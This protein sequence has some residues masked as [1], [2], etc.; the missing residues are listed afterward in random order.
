[1]VCCC[2]TCRRCVP[3]RLEEVIARRS[4]RPFDDAIHGQDDVLAGPLADTN[5]PR[6]SAT[7]SA[8]PSPSSPRPC[9]GDA[10]TAS[11][12]PQPVL[13]VNQPAQSDDFDRQGAGRRAR[14]LSSSL[15]PARTDPARTPENSLKVIAKIDFLRIFRR[16]AAKE[17]QLRNDRRSQ[18]QATRR[19]SRRPAPIGGSP[20]SEHRGPRFFPIHQIVLM[21]EKRSYED[22]A[23]RRDEIQQPADVEELRDC[24]LTAPIFCSTSDTGDVESSPR[25]GSASSG[26][27]ASA[28]VEA[29]RLYAAAHEGALPAKLTDVSVP[30]P[31]DP[32][33]GQ[34]FRYELI[35]GTA[36]LRGSPP[37]GEEKRPVQPALRDHDPQVTPL[38]A[39]S[40]CP[41][42]FL[43]DPE[44]S[45]AMIP[46]LL[47]AVSVVSAVCRRAGNRDSASVRPMAAPKPARSSTSCCPR[48]ELKPG[49]PTQWYVRCF[50]EQRNF[51]FSKEATVERTRYQS[52]PLADLP[53]EKLR[54]Y[55]GSAPR[56][57]RIGVRGWT[58]PTGKCSTRFRPR[59][60]PRF[61]SQGSRLYQS[62][63]GN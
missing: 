59:R 11:G 31:V 23:G 50:A 20:A 45:S 27:P 61:T 12:L 10:G 26:S 49:N 51:F 7:W 38:W 60:T 15:H 28:T 3:G 22:R 25:P 44:G 58:P 14:G 19:S 57:R 17:D 41:G 1:M 32:F 47:M 62:G 43:H 40:E 13:G 55:G 46:F 18:L 39:H 16:H 4:L 35:D 63:G 54:D 2:R 6:L 21:D 53:G 52:M 48:C 9:S 30:L 24:I 56:H 33:T 37:K 42:R 29:L 34:P 5:T 36:H 8:S